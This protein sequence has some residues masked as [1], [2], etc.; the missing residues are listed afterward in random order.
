M[1]GGGVVK[2]LIENHLQTERVEVGERAEQRIDFG[3][4]GDVVAHAV[5]VVVLGGA[6][7]ALVHDRAS[8]PAPGAGSSSLC[9]SG[10][11]D[12]S[13][14]T[15]YLVKTFSLSLTCPIDGASVTL[16]PLRHGRSGR[17]PG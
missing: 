10:M 17:H 5:P 12:E 3:V 13:T 11:A 16:V 15:V 7:V 1:D 2:H 14:H 8:P 6:G 9:A 4:I